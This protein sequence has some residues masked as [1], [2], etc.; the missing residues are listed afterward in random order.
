MHLSGIVGGACLVVTV[1]WEAFETIV[2]PR[3]V[4]RRFR[5]TRVFYRA[6]WVPTRAIGR[7]CTPK[8]SSDGLLS[9]FGPISLLGLLFAW[10]GML[11]LGYALLQW[12]AGSELQTPAGL[13]GF[14]ADLYFSGATLFTL[15][16]GDIVPSS[17]L[18]RLLAVIEGGTGLGFFALVIG[19]LPV[20]SQAFSRREVNITLLDPRGGSPPSAG[21]LLVR[22]SKVD[23]AET[24]GE[25]LQQWDQWAAELLETHISFPVLAY[26]RS[27][28]DNQSWVAALTTILDVCALILAGLEHGPVQRARLT[29]AMARHAAV[30]LSR[31]F[32]LEPLAPDPDRL[33]TAELE[34]LRAALRATGLTLREGPDVDEKLHRLRRMYEPYMNALGVFLLMPLPTWLS[35]EGSR[36]NWLS[37][38]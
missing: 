3:R 25:L 11:V 2:F 6:I 26:Y 24:L 12:G 20:V 21:E 27:Q 8:K 35:P 37:T 36:D 9:I 13:H 18:A 23:N 15:S 28:H 10:A 5:L 38:A 16:L 30:D 19:Y 4:S 31:I 34:R 14:L 22:H 17:K 33:P 29:F 7:R 32:R 1:L